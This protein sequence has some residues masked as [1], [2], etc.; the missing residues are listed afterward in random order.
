MTTQTEAPEATE[1]EAAPVAA[2]AVAAP[3]PTTP[4]VV[5]AAPK[6]DSTSKPQKGTTLTDPADLQA[7][8]DKTRRE[9]AGYRQRATAAEAGLSAV[10]ETLKNPDG[11][12]ISSPTGPAPDGEVTTEQLQKQLAD[13]NLAN[14]LWRVA[15]QV[16]ADP[17]LLIPHLR[18][19]GQIDTLD[20]GDPLLDAALLTMAQAALAQYPQLTVS[21]APPP[22]PSAPGDP[23]AG[24]TLARTFTRS[25]IKAFTPEQH[26]DEALQAQ[27]DDWLRA[28]APE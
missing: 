27:V 25:E 20:S 21:G 4:D 7:L 10:Q 9:A 13:A 2:P 3:P 26:A 14:A 28:G 1:E 5:P 23:P 16:G 11:P 24:P 19:T 8:L 22:P 15:P 6:A 12:T 18:G 17:S